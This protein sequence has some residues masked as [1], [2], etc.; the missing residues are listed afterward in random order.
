MAIMDETARR[1]LALEH[2][3]EVACGSG[4]AAEPRRLGQMLSVRAE[5]RLAEALRETASRR[6]TTVSELLRDA[7]V[8]LVAADGYCRSCF[9]P[10]S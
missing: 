9:T 6:G 7:A 4:R 5:P 3:G 2:A 10:R 1:A 8:E